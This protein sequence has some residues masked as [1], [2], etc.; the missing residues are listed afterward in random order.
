[1]RV[2]I[3][4]R[5]SV[6]GST[7]K[8]IGRSASLGAAGCDDECPGYRLA[9]FVGSLWPGETAEDFGYPVSDDG[10]IEVDDHGELSR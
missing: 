10:T 2:G 3:V 7:K 6:C 9:P 8:P 5:C 4:V 1:M